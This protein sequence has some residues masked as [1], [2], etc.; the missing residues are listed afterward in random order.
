[1]F[2]RRL[3]LVVLLIPSLALATDIEGVQPA[4]LDQPRINVLL[5]RAPNGAPLEV[6][7]AG[8]VN[9]Q[10]FLDTGAS[11]VMLSPKTADALGIRRDK[12]KGAS[13]NPTS[14]IFHDVGVSGTDNFNV[15]EPLHASLMRFH[16]GAEGDGPEEYK[17]HTGPFRAQIGPL[18]GGFD[19]LDL[20]MSNLDV[21]G[22]PVLKGKV[23]V[24]DPKPVNKFDDT[25]RTYVYEPKTRFDQ[26][27]AHRDP[28]IPKTNRHV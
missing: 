4:S 20:V 21:V 26:G 13:G 28:G 7:D 6:K 9:I 17:L 22:M 15:A 25:M 10:G 5:R 2:P 1:M 16:S 27:N 11:G 12:S 8:F 18:G 23:M 24:M 19:L 3:T 14:I